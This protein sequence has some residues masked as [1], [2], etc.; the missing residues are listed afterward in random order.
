MNN[1]IVIDIYEY[2]ILIPIGIALVF[3]TIKEFVNPE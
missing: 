2:C 1:N 3:L